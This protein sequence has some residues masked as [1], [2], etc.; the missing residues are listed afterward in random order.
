[1]HMLMSSPPDGI[2]HG[3]SSPRPTAWASRSMNNKVS[4]IISIVII[5]IIIIISSS[6]SS[7]TTTAT[8][9]THIVTTM[10][11][12]AASCS[13]PWRADMSPKPR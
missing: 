5:M 3:F 11:L 8:T 2:M 1:M 12:S 4:C 10:S 13:I 9:A 7:T 6:S